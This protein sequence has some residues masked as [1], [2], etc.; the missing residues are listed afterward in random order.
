M[1]KKLSNITIENARL[2]HRNFS[3]AATQFNP[4]GKRNCSVVLD[5]E[6]A[7]QL[8]ADG[9]NVKSKPP[10]DPQ[11]EPLFYLPMEIR[12][13]PIAPNIFMITSRGKTRLDESN[14]NLLDSAIIRSAD[15]MIHPRPWETAN[16][17]G[18]KAY[19]RTLFATIEED[20]LELKYAD[21]PTAGR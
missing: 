10:R 12:F 2:I 16:G 17:K 20:E 6:F 5:P 7:Q 14:V 8:I 18:I 21:I 11:D 1:E 4:P 9:W 19:L 13:D 15:L 3:G